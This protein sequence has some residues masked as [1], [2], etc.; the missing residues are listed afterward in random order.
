MSRVLVGLIL[1]PRFLGVV[2]EGGHIDAQTKLKWSSTVAYEW[3]VISSSVDEKKRVEMRCDNAIHQP[4][5][6][7]DAG[8]QDFATLT[9]TM[10]LERHALYS[11]PTRCSP[12]SIVE[13]SAPLNGQMLVVARMMPG[14]LFTCKHPT[15]LGKITCCARMC[16]ATCGSVTKDL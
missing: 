14:A 12:T 7:P 6:L 1:P 2:G 4:I 13:Q 9:F 8:P 10:L 11:K 5:P 15:V 3:S 16:G